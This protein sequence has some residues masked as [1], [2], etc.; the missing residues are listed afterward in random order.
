M[1]ASF[2]RFELKMTLQQAESCSH[3]G[4]CEHDV[5][6]LMEHPL[7]KRQ[8]RKIAPELIRQELREWGS[9]SEEE[10]A[11]DDSNWMRIL[12]IGANNITEEAFMK[13]SNRS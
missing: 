7:I 13:R 9:W 5:R 8:R 2:E 3:P 12:W 1:W 11:Y 4:D 10:L 6:S